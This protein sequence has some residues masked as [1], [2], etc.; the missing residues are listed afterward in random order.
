MIFNARIFASKKS[1]AALWLVIFGYLF[2]Y[3][4][5]PF[6]AFFFALDFAWS[7]IPGPIPLGGMFGIMG[8]IIISFGF[9]GILPF[10]GILA[11]DFGF[12]FGIVITFFLI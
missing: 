6:L 2:R 8:C 4:F 7:I 5:P 10:M 9:I 1:L 12:A 3:F 11:C